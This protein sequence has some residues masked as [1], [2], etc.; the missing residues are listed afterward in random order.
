MDSSNQRT[1][2]EKLSR[3]FLL[4]SLGFTYDSDSLHS[5]NGRA[6]IRCDAFKRREIV[7][8][9]FRG[10]FY[11]DVVQSNDEAHPHKEVGKHGDGGQHF[12]VRNVAEE[13]QRQHQG[14]N[15]DAVIHVT[16]R[17]HVYGEN[18]QE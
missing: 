11:G 18:L 9:V 6:E 14:G 1:A 8:I 17:R 13:N 15:E 16:N 7:E 12:E 2:R 3:L 10:Q 5:E 4:G